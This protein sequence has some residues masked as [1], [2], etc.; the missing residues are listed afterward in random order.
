MATYQPRD[1]INAPE[2]KAQIKKRSLVRQDSDEIRAWLINHFFRYVIGNWQATEP[3][4]KKLATLT[5]AQD[6]LSASDKRSVPPWLSKRFQ[7]AEKGQRLPPLWWIDPASEGLLAVE[8]KLIEFLQ[9]RQGTALEGKLQRINALQA[10]ALWQTE[11]AAMEARAA[12]NW[13][14]HEPEA[15]QEIW[16]DAHGVLVEFKFDS[17]HLRAEMAY[18]SQIMRHCLGQ[19]ADRRA[20]TGGYGAQYAEACEAGQLKLYSYRTGAASNQP[21]IT[22]SAW[23]CEGGTVRIDQIKG[24]QN[25]PPIDSYRAS[26]LGFLN[27]LPTSLDTPGDAVNMGIARCGI[28]W[29]NISEVEDEASQLRLIRRYPALFP[30]LPHPQ[31]LLQWLVAVTDPKSLLG[32]TL[33]PTLQKVMESAT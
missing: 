33:T 15:V 5:A 28:N 21:R 2:I 13:R 3:A 25:R 16:R 19:F 14:T 22:I 30:Q 17:P 12:N 27:S 29:R 20:L 32:K 24:K 1:V 8:N 11:H 23:V 6:A 18:E 26:V 31:P 7:G 4:L 10:L 9:A